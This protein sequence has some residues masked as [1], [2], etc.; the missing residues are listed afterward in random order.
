MSGRD[1]R[2]KSGRGGGPESVADILGRLFASRGWGRRSGR[3]QL[4]R[5]WAEAAGE[6]YAGDTRVAS[7]RGGRLEVEVRDSVLMQELTQFHKR[8]LLGELRRLMP[9]Q[10]VT[11]IRF[12]AAA[13]GDT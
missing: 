2:D 10:T 11:D 4:E 9:S 7:L 6:E 12:R 13:W 1:K 5:A 3:L 8:R